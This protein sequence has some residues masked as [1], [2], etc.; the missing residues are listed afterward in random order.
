MV[1]FYYLTEIVIFYFLHY[2]ETF[3]EHLTDRSDT[4]L[5]Q[6]IPIAET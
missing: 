5:I 6:A 1:I 3:R 4:S 2:L